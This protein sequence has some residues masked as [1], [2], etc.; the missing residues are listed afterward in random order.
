MKQLQE[1][2]SEKRELFDILTLSVEMDRT[3][4]SLNFGV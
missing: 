1:R 4:T 3:V 2:I